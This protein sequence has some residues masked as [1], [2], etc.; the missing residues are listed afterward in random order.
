MQM[1]LD[2]SISSY[3]TFNTSRDFSY[4]RCTKCAED[5]FVIDDEY[6]D[7]VVC[8]SCRFR[9]TRFGSKKEHL[10]MIYA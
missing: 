6:Y 10:Q 3:N 1:L 2:D 9:A 4:L 5:S 7:M 8:P